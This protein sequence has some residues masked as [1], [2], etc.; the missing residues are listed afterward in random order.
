M[1]LSCAGNDCSGLMSLPRNMSAVMA[2]TRKHVLNQGAREKYSDNGS[3]QSLIRE[4]SK[5]ICLTQFEFNGY[6]A[7]SRKA[8]VSRLQSKVRE[9]DL[10][11]L[12]INDALKSVRSRNLRPKRPT[13]AQGEFHR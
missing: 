3:G 13:D 4:T 1:Y 12:L 10:S 11:E 9:F 8:L 6:L 7:C 2:C 5:L